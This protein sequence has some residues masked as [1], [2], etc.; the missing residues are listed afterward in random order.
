M[1]TLLALAALCL[2]MSVVAQDKIAVKVGD[3]APAIELPAAN[4]GADA[5]PVN[6]AD[7][8]GKK[9]VVLFFYPRAMTKGCTIESCG[10]RDLQKD[11]AGADTVIFGISTDKVEAQD[12]FIKKENL[13][14]PLLADNEQK[15][16][17]SLGVMGKGTATQRVT[18]VI[19][20]EGK[21]AKI[22]DKVTP[23]TH[24]KEV[25][26]FIKTLK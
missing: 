23:A 19:D 17:K 5:K 24:P 2:P 6:L 3:A 21:I 1:R 12:Q 9:N 14:F 4:P 11:F 26:E 25:L 16:S 18:F 8:K 20:K 15:V 7:F 10:F 13:N 22:Y